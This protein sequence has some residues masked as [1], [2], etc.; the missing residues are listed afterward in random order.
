MNGLVPRT[1]SPRVL[2]R[3]DVG[4]DSDSTQETPSFPGPVYLAL[5][6]YAGEGLKSRIDKLQRTSTV[7]TA[8]PP[9]LVHL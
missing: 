5:P 7:K 2:V 8:V 9:R 1:I 3:S 6:R 4:N